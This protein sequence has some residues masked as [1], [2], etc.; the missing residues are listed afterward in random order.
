MSDE[1]KIQDYEHARRA[2]IRE[3]DGFRMNACDHVSDDRFHRCPE[4]G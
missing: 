1:L 2:G 3:R 4:V